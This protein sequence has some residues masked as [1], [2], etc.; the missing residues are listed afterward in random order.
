MR[1][2]GRAGLRESVGSAISSTLDSEEDFDPE[3]PDDD[4][5]RSASASCTRA[6]RSR[7]RFR[8]RVAAGLCAWLPQNARCRCERV[9]ALVAHLQGLGCV[10]SPRTLWLRSHRTRVS[11][12]LAHGVRRS[13]AA[14]CD[15]QLGGGQDPGEPQHRPTPRAGLS[16]PCSR[17]L[18]HALA[19]SL[20]FHLGLPCSASPSR[21]LSLCLART[22]RRRR[23]SRGVQRERRGAR[24]REE[25][26]RGQRGLEARCRDRG[27]RGSRAVVQGRA[28]GFWVSLEDEQIQHACPRMLWPSAEATLRVTAARDVSRAWHARSSFRKDRESQRDGARVL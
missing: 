12:V 9:E 17:S 20:A 3:A 26:V 4:H 22:L 21:A 18:S 24:G 10:A 13:C 8:M 23:S 6:R 11:R 7:A 1:A 27:A 19:R 2:S 28:C 25:R 14:E 16:P 15:V 5:D